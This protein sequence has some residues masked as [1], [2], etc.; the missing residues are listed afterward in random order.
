[1]LEL[2]ELDIG[3]SKVYLHVLH[4]SLKLTLF[5]E[6]SPRDTKLDFETEASIMANFYAYVS[7]EGLSYY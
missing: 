4:H 3:A 5:L 6:H 7:Y 1:M 2:K